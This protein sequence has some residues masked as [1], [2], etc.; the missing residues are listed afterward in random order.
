MQKK[1]KSKTKKFEKKSHKAETSR[2]RRPKSA[3]YLGLKKIQGTAIVFNYHSA[4]K[5]PK[6][7][8]SPKLENSELETSEKN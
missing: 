5:Y 2:D 4:K 7:V 1:I 3:P 8:S 6:M